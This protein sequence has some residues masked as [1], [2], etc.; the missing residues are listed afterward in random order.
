MAPSVSEC[1]SDEG[2]SRIRMHRERPGVSTGFERNA[3][4]R[5][6][7]PGIGRRGDM[8]RFLDLIKKLLWIDDTPERTAL[9]FS[10]GIFLGFSPFLGFHTLAGIAIAF[11]FRLN[12]VAVLFGVWSNSPWWL[13]PYY[14]VATW[15]GTKV[16]GF[17]IDEAAIAEIFRLG[18]DHGFLDFGFWKQ[19]SS[20]AGLLLSFLHR[21]VAL[22][23]LPQFDRLSPL[24]EVDQVLSF[25]ETGS[26]PSAVDRLDTHGN[27]N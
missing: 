24:S 20:Q 21:I 17:R 12:R 13:V 5:F 4:F 27:F 22:L 25:K 16:I 2:V 8:R 11:M 23:S 15:V 14:I 18:M 7:R 26:D 19:L 10:V 1:F 9:A 6:L 3:P